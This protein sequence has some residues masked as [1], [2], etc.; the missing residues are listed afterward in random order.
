L[1]NKQALYQITEQ[2]RWPGREPA[3]VIAAKYRGTVDE[4]GLQTKPVP[5]EWVAPYADIWHHLHVNDVP[6]QESELR[7]L[8]A[9]HGWATF[10]GLDLFG[11]EGL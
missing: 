10:K 1:L 2:I 6:W 9:Q 4:T 5:E 8:I 7:R 11:F 3:H